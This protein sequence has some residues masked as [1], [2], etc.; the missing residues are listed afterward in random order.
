MG[1]FDPTRSADVHK[2]TL[3]ELRIP[4]T[5]QGRARMTVESRPV[6]ERF[7]EKVDKNGPTMAHMTTPC[8]MWQAKRSNVGYGHFWVNGKTV[9]AH[10][11]SFEIHYGP[12]GELDVCHECDNRPCVRSDHLFKG[13][14]ADNSADMVT[15]SRQATGERNGLRINPER[16]A[17]GQR[18]GHFTHPEATPRGEDVGMAKLTPGEIVEIRECYALGNITLAQLASRFNV[19]RS[20]IGRIVNRRLWQHIR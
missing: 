20:T 4:Q 7:W 9:L 2:R 3:G 17:K 8:W 16:A 19:N 10:R 13:T 6:E 14:A 5:A 1:E 15:K 11:F 12:A 18:N